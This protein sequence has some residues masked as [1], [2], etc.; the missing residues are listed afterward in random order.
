MGLYHDASRDEARRLV[1][2]PQIAVGQS[3]RRCGVGEEER[4]PAVSWVLS[5]LVLFKSVVF[6]SVMFA[7]VSALSH[8][9]SLTVCGTNRNSQ[10]NP[11]SRFRLRD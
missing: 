9:V 7:L 10:Q 5:A 8:I 1:H 3:S 4:T 6:A 2:P 11:M